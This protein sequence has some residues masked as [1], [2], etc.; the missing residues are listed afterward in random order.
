MKKIMLS[1]AAVAA[2]ASVASAEDAWFNGG[3]G[4]GSL[5]GGS[6]TDPLPEGVTQPSSSY[7]LE[8]VADPLSFTATTPKAADS[9]QNL[10]FA[11]SAKFAY[12][13]DE[14]PAV[15][16]S[17]KAGVVVY[18]N[19]YYVL[20][21]DVN[22]NPASNVW[23]STYIDATLTDPVDVSVTITNG[24]DGAHALYQFGNST[25]IDKLV[26][27]AGEWGAV[28]YKGS[29]EVA[30]L[31]GTT[32]SLGWPLP[33][34]GSIAVDPAW[35][36]ANGIDAEAFAKFDKLANGFS[37]SES[38]ILGLNTNEAFVASLGKSADG[39]K[40]VLAKPNVKVADRVSFDVYLD[41]VKA[42]DG[43]LPKDC[44]TRSSAS[45]GE[46]TIQLRPKVSGQDTTGTSQTIGIWTTQMIASNQVDYVTI[47]YECAVSNCLWNLNNENHW[48]YMDVYDAASGNWDRWKVY[49]NSTTWEYVPTADRTT[50]ITTVLK[51]GQAVKV[52]AGDLKQA[53]GDKKAFYRVGTKVDRSKTAVVSGTW[54]LVGNPDGGKVSLSLIAGTDKIRAFDPI[55]ADA[56]YHAL[57]D[58]SYTKYGDNWYKIPLNGTGTV[59]TEIDSGV[60]G[61]FL[62][63]TGTEVK[64][65]PT[66]AK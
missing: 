56:N 23:V 27:A 36:E 44:F 39:D 8:N 5:S 4:A 64:W 66:A 41:G 22:S 24:T 54:N 61:F 20:A 37:A 63:A 21:K 55:A 49:N 33:G 50:P 1:F 30:S 57:P 65:T 34:G 48:D 12:S 46:H 15:D 43:T 19:K 9:S 42:E 53:F 32:I 28:D 62:Y 13:Y 6:W 60:K 3:L 2:F 59:V 7:V 16:S 29:G 31:V 52:T 25:A 58:V 45:S 47:P 18:D 10:N 38:Y 40:F 11:T 17:A 51:P 26:A 14:L 35:A